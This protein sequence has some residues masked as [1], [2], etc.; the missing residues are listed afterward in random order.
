M[1]LHFP[2][3]EEDISDSVPCLRNYVSQST[4]RT[5]MT[6]LLELGSVSVLEMLLLRVPNGERVVG[7]MISSLSPILCFC[8]SLWFLFSVV[9]FVCVWFVCV[10]VCVCVC[11]RVCARACVCFSSVCDW[12]VLVVSLSLGRYVL[13]SFVYCMPY[14]FIRDSVGVQC[15]ASTEVHPKSCRQCA[16]LQVRQNHPEGGAQERRQE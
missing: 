15:G 7:S 11:V 12:R 2:K 8:F 14:H 3:S 1:I 4:C 16:S 6:G 10:C 5:V 9:L 13:H